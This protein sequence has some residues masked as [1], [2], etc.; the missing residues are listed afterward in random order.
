MQPFRPLPHPFPRA[1]RPRVNL[2]EKSLKSPIGVAVGVGLI[3]VLGLVALVRLPVQLFP[4]IE[5]PA[6]TIFTGWRAAAPTEVEAEL[7]EPQEQ[8]LRGLAGPPGDPVVRERGRRIH[9]P[10]VRDRHRHGPHAHRRDR[11]HEPA[12][13]AAARRRRTAHLARR[14]R[15]RRAERDVVLVLR[16]AE[17]GHAGPGRE[18]PARGR[19]PDALARRVD[20]GRGH[21][22]RQR[23]RA[24]RASHRV[25]P[26]PRGGARHPDPVHRQRR[27]QRRR[28][29]RRFRRARPAPVHAALR[30]PLPA[31]RP[32][33]AGARLARRPSRAPCRR[34]DDLGRARRPQLARLAEQ[35]PGDRHPDPEG[36]R[37]GRAGDAE[38]REGRDR[39]AARGPARR[40]RPRHR[41]VLRSVGVHQ[42]GNRPRHRK[43]RRGRHP[44]DRRAVAVPAPVPLHA[45]G[46]HR[47]PGIRARYRAR[48]AGD[49]SHAQRHLD[50]RHRLCRRHDARRRDH[51]AGE[52][53]PAPRARRVPGPGR[54]RGRDARLAG[55]VRI[56]ADDRDRVHSRDLHE[57]HRGAALCRPRAHDL[58]RDRG[59]ARDGDDSTAGGRRALAE[60]DRGDAQGRRMAASA[61][62]ADG[63]PH[64]QPAP[65]PGDDRPVPRRARGADLVAACRRST[66]CRR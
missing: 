3:I 25:R 41:A 17:A 4:D 61:R 18:L 38:R 66:T 12:A 24:R 58:G 19:G 50:R 8:A 37:R 40:P 60:A 63:R 62:R 13:A 26:L 42:P 22:Q 6:I 5:E 2:T 29:L 43:P 51:R 47:D 1:G 11:A 45:P 9:Q 32:R 57:E 65:A 56:D 30:G 14:E 15:W 31:G 46:R 7:I 64:R 16:A 52:H 34:C 36:V 35:Q 49:G 53:P 39:G 48:D 27:R 21:D 59:L 28:R 20:P 44:R 10:R 55:A 33:R 23:G 54:A